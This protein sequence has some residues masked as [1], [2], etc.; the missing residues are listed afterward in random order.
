MSMRWPTATL[1]EKASGES[2]VDDDERR[3]GA[4]SESVTSFAEQRSFQRRE[5]PGMDDLEIRCLKLL[6]SASASPL[7]PKDGGRLKHRQPG[8][9][10]RR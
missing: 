7:S 9:R 5:Y 10:K 3:S 2:V 4:L 6:G 1:R 8:K